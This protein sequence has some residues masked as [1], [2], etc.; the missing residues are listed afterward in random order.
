[1]PCEFLIGDRL[2]EELE[3]FG[4]RLIQVDLLRLVE[5]PRPPGADQAQGRVVGHARDV[6]ALGGPS[7]IL[8][9]VLIAPWSLGE[10]QGNWGSRRGRA[11]E[12]LHRPGEPAGIAEEM[13][14]TWGSRPRV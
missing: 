2:P 11:S 13:A 8:P 12:L 4:E 5:A 14:G 7:E 6:V 10:W 9:A 1:M 3:D